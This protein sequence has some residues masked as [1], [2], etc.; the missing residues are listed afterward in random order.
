MPYVFPKRQAKNEDVNATEDL[1]YE[2]VTATEKYGKLNPHDFAS[3]IQPDV[4]EDAYY[5]VTYATVGVDP[6]FGTFAGWLAPSKPGTNEQA[7]PNDGSW[8]PLTDIDVDPVTGVSVL[9]IIARVQYIWL[10]FDN[11]P[12]SWDINTGGHA[13]SC[14][15][16][17]SAR[18]YPA[19]VQF[20]VVVNGRVIDLT[21][22]GMPD[23]YDD[24]I[25][26]EIPVVFA[27]AT[28]GQPGPRLNVEPNCSS[29]NSEMYSVRVGAMVPVPSGTQSVR[30]I[31]RRL[32]LDRVGWPGYDPNDQVVVFSRQLMAMELP[33]YAGGTV[34][35]D[36]IDTPNLD[37][38]DVFSAQAVGTDRINAVRTKYNAVEPG[39][40]SRGALDHMHLKSLIPTGASASQIKT[41]TP[42]GTKALATY[43][44]GFETAA[45]L[46]V[47]PS[48]G[49]G[50]YPVESTAG[51]QLKTGAITIDGKCW[52]VIIGNVQLV[53]INAWTTGGAIA[54]RRNLLN[55]A[56]FS[57]IYKPS[58]GAAVVAP[59]SEAYVNAYNRVAS[60][61]YVGGSGV[62]DASPEGHDRENVDVPVFAVLEFGGGGLP[63]GNLD[64]VGLYSS[65]MGAVGGAHVN[66]VVRRGSLIVLK[67]DQE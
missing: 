65:V 62:A 34:T 8:T 47:S 18:M 67:V 15:G 14:S 45:P 4:T 52:L 21:M 56:A 22:T 5:K 42:A 24:G 12:A 33:V 63:I 28:Y 38:E 40:L 60:N 44:P 17:E 59:G 50:W 20:A 32:G 30:I 1:N 51:N 46:P 26:G 53:M 29:I 16:A 64:Y 25:R 27:G 36:S 49:D 6:G 58:S 13:Y 2:V 37:P 7:I 35:Y 23:A 48:P 11:P 43:Y 61:V 9:W 31:A 39:A 3:A 54:R 10:G 66:A 57:I 55:T 19:R 41:L